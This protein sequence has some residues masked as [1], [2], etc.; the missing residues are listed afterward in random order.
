MVDAAFVLA[1]V[2]ARSSTFPRLQTL[3]AEIESLLLVCCANCA[4]HTE[5]SQVLSL[6]IRF[7]PR[8]LLER[9]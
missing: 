8:T 9:T 5:V 4:V 6:H 7:T 3:P 1:V 2:R